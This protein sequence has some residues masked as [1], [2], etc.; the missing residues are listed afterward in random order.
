[1]TINP[2]YILSFASTLAM[3]IY[4]IYALIALTDNIKS[5]SNRL[6]AA[7]CL[8]SAI[9]SFGFAVS[10]S[11]PIM[12]T[13]IRFRQISAVGYIF[14]YAVLLHMMLVFT[15]KT[16]LL[17]FPIVRYGI[18]LPPFILLPIFTI[19]L[20]GLKFDYQ[21]VQTLWG[22]THHASP[23][24]LDGIFYV[25]YIS[26]TS[27]AFGL[28][29]HHTIRSIGK[30]NF[31]QNLILTVTILV[32]FV[33]ASATDILANLIF[34]TPI[35]QL[36]PIILL[37]PISFSLFIIEHYGLF[38]HKKRDLR[39]KIIRYNAQNPIIRNI[40][41]PFLFGGL[42][43][44]AIG[45]FKGHFTRAYLFSVGSFI[46]LVG[47]VLHKIL[48]SQL[49]DSIKDN[50]VLI[51]VSTLLP[52][53]LF[54]SMA[55]EESSTWAIPIVFIF[56]FLLYNNH[57]MILG[58]FTTAFLSLLTIHMIKPSYATAIKFS[59]HITQYFIY[60]MIVTFALIINHYYVL[61]MKENQYQVDSSKLIARLSSHMVQSESEHFS[62]TMT[63]ALCEIGEFFKGDRV[64]FYKV[65]LKEQVMTYEQSWTRDHI[66]PH[67]DVNKKLQVAKFGW[68]LDQLQMN[69][70]VKIQDVRSMPK[71]AKTIQTFLDANKTQSILTVALRKSNELVGF[72]A[73]DAVE[74]VRHWED[75]D[76][77]TILILGNIISEVITKNAAEIRLKDLAYYDQLTGLPSRTLFI[78]HFDRAV[79]MAKRN[80]TG[81]CIGMLDL[82][83]FKNINDTLGHDKGD[84]ML[85]MIA[86][87]LSN[88]L[89]KTDVISRFGGDEFVL[90][91]EGL[92]KH[93]TLTTIGNELVTIFHEPFIL[94]GHPY[95]MT[96][97][98]GLTYSKAEPFD[99]AEMIKSADQAMYKAKNSGK[100]SFKCHT[101]LTTSN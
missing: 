39:T 35:P 13:S 2:T 10:Y 31:R 50:Y 90:L 64:T 11:T 25:Y 88:Y 87:R 66:T 98:I 75:A 5:N 48:L 70:T 83:G 36:S 85:Q 68:W 18:Y 37:F 8:T 40:W 7:L 65:N 86:Q 82:D 81:I 44:I 14:F 4:V 78:N 49:S 72:I 69:N 99:L 58:I 63:T 67:K 53:L 59:D 93:D 56:A 30:D 20:F 57:K 62:A 6:F 26:Y 22:W 76:Q 9:W 3:S 95:K 74:H 12:A 61:R 97:S 16:R 91:F 33:L 41:M 29:I 45:L 46:Y 23:N 47:V 92:N 60:I 96:G 79:S 28:V 21:M 24:Q 1:M 15:N 94:N 73:V 89:R 38:T 51:L 80:K 100:N 84:E 43:F 54:H 27:L 55:F 52:L 32:T 42:L 101:R 34:K 77:R 71:E 17:S 19:G